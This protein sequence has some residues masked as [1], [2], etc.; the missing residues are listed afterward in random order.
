MGSLLAEVTPAPRTWIRKARTIR[1]TLRIGKPQIIPAFVAARSHN[2]GRDKDELRETAAKGGES[3]GGRPPDTT[4][5]PGSFANWWVTATTDKPRSVQILTGSTG[6]RTSF[7]RLLPRAGRRAT[8]VA[9]PA[10]IPTSR[11]ET[12]GISTNLTMIGLEY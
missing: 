10:W 4:Y 2:D 11:Y 12:P 3:T 9:S 1:A 5:N 6:Q 8:A 7:E